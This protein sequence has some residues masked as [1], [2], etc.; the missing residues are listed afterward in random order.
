MIVTPQAAQS[1]SGD[2]VMSRTEQPSSSSFF[3]A[4]SIAW[5]VAALASLSR[6]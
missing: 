1:A 5:R 2:S 6:S 3:A 4:V